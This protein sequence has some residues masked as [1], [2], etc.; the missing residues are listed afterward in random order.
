VVTEQVIAGL[1][2][3]DPT[4]ELE[5]TFRFAAAIETAAG[6]R[7]IDFAAGIYDCGTPAAYA[8]SKMRFPGTVRTD[9]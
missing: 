4:S 2:S 1:R 3:A 6:V 9:V 8:Q 5:L 7:P